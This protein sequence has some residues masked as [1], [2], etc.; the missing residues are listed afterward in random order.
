MT[1]VCLVSAA[2]LRLWCLY[3]LPGAAVIFTQS[4]GRVTDCIYYQ[5]GAG[6]LL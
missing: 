3:L 2:D 5:R 1:A 6:W 4:K